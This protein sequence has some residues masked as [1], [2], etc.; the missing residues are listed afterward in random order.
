[1]RREWSLTGLL[2]GWVFDKIWRAF[3]IADGKRKTW[4]GSVRDILAPKAKLVTCKI[5][6]SY[7]IFPHGEPHSA[8]E[9]EKAKEPKAE[10]DGRNRSNIGVRNK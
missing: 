6:S 1:M 4:K 10:K 7:L 2:V 8:R 5:I 9:R 3:S